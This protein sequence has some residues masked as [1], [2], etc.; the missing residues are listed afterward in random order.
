MSRS[1]RNGFTLV[2][3][4]VVIAIIGVLVALLLPAVQQAREAARRMQCTNNLKQVGLALHNY[5][6]TFR[7]LPVNAS[8]VSPGTEGRFINSVLVTLLPYLEQKNVYDFARST[9][10]AAPWLWS[11]DAGFKPMLGNNISAYICPSDGNSANPGPNAPKTN[12]MACFG[13]TGL[14]ISQNAGQDVSDSPTNRGVFTQ[15]HW[16][17]LNAVTDGTSNTIAFGEAVAAAGLQDRRVKGGA[18]VVSLNSGYS[19]SAMNCMNAV[20]PNN[21]NLL[22]GSM[23]NIGNAARGWI[24]GHYSPLYTG[25]STILPPNSPTCVPIQSD[26]VWG[27]Y[28]GSSNHPGGMNVGFTDGSVRFISENIDC[29]G[30]PTVTMG[31]SAQSTEQTGVSPF[32]VWGALGTPSGGEVI[33]EF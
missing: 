27:I 22:A 10:G 3:L 23:L 26:S 18:A 28:S 1:C 11:H 29:N 20:D 13:D 6:D 16:K 12:V 17:G 5:H 25:F 33:G 19:V 8:V 7:S 32:G 9:P 21:R 4:L 15:F 2:E 14:Q 31:T 30:I 24:Y